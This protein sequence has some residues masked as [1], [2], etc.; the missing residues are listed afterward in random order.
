MKCERCGKQI[1]DRFISPLF[2]NGVYTNVDPECALE[3][4]SEVHGREITKF[5]GQ[6]A[7]EMLEDFQAFK[8]GK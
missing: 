7:Q 8:K 4:M 5:R 1:P 3:I 6:V 2:A